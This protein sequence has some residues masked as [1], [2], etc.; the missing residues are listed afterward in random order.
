M[1]I[2]IC[3]YVRMDVHENMYIYVYRHTCIYI[4]THS[5]IYINI[6]SDAL[7]RQYSVILLE[8]VYERN[9]DILPILL[10]LTPSSLPH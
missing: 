6:T 7:L 4:Y 10:T 8:E 5:C 2:D 9:T 3:V 1:Y